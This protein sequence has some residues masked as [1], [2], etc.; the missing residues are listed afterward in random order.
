MVHKIAHDRVSSLC[1]VSPI[2]CWTHFPGSFSHKSGMCSLSYIWQLLVSQSGQMFQWLTTLFSVL[3]SDVPNL[4]LRVPQNLCGV[5]SIPTS[6]VC[7]L[8][9][10][11]YNEMTEESLVHIIQTFLHIHPH[12]PT[13]YNH[14]Q[15]IYLI[16]KTPYQVKGPNSSQ[17]MV[18]MHKIQ[19]QIWTF[20]KIMLCCQSANMDGH[21][22]H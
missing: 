12:I 3:T 1:C 16:C 7:S 13:R 15:A 18:S 4:H 9:L 2:A 5:L 19:L 22:I 10:S 6:K 21:W 17:D 14:I 11:V 8:L 20:S